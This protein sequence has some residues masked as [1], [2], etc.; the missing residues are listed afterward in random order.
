MEK[1]M[2]NFLANQPPRTAAQMSELMNEMRKKRE[3]LGI[4]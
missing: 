1:G 2:A 4:R 3:G